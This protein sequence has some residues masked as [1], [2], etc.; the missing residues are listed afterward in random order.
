MAGKSKFTRDNP[1]PGGYKVDFRWSKEKNDY[2]C[3]KIYWQEGITSY[4]CR[5][6]RK[7]VT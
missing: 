1:P 5:W 7:T 2:V 3:S 4:P 6:K